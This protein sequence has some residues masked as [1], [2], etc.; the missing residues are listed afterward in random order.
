MVRCRGDH[1]VTT[2][3][4]NEYGIAAL[5]NP[6]WVETFQTLLVCVPFPFDALASYHERSASSEMSIFRQSHYAPSKRRTRFDQ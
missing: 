1:M 4:P 3:D 6:H 5:N 2:C